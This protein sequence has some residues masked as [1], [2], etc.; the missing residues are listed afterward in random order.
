S[1]RAAGN[2]E[3]SQQAEKLRNKKDERKSGNRMQIEYRDIM[4][5]MKK[6]GIS[7]LE[8]V[9]PQQLDQVQKR[10]GIV[11][12]GELRRFYMEGMPVSDGF[13][14]WLDETPDY[15]ESVKRKL[16]AP[17][18]GVMTAVELEEVWPACWGERPEE[19]SQALEIAGERL[20]D[21]SVLIPLYAH[22]YVSCLE[23]TDDA[24][25]LSVYGGDIIYYGANLK[26]WLQIEFCGLSR[27]TVF[28]S[29]LPEIPG[30]QT[31]IS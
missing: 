2:C 28:E 14:R 23:Q 25:V 4:E 18:R 7:F 29:E 12:P 22:R 8:D 19:E 13:V 15:V 27:R 31:L 1:S 21:A 30:W 3:E 11:F 26:N 6:Q 5:Q 16:K 9:T 10:Y 17:V 24:P 20:G